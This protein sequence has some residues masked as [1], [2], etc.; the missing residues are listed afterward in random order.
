[1]KKKGERWKW[2]REANLHAPPRPRIPHH[3]ILYP[4]ADTAVL[5]ADGGRR[6]RPRG[7]VEG[8]EFVEGGWDGGVKEGVVVGV[9]GADFVE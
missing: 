9:V 3:Y 8:G 6:W 7:A 1:M 2:R 5:R 4:P